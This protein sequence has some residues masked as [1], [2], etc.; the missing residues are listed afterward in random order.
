M[1]DTRNTAA[2][3][4]TG[5]MTTVNV[6]SAGVPA[7]AK[8]VSLN[9]T[10]TGT[11]GAGFVTVFPCDAAQPETSNLNFAGGQTIANAVLAT[12]SAAGTICLFNSIGTELIVDIG[13]YLPAGFAYERHHA[14]AAP[15]HPQ[16]CDGPGGHGHPVPV[17]GRN[18]V[19]ADAVAVGAQRHRRHRRRQRVCHGVPVW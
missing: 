17:T 19:A 6:T 13:G 18:G 1:L 10:V 3:V 7:D 12:P 16:W 8:A 14:G 11:T 5:S 9:V 15:R 4:P 2:V